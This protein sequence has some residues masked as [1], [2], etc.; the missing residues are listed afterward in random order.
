MELNCKTSYPE[1]FETFWKSYPP[2]GKPAS[3]NGK[4]PAMDVWRRM[5][6]EQRAEAMAAVPQQIEWGVLNQDPQFIPM[7]MTWL[8]QRRWLDEKPEGPKGKG[9]SGQDFENE[10]KLKEAWE[11]GW[12]E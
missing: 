9:L 8:R 3:R 2:R 4:G 6:Q 1:D 5:S 11:G 7:A 12:D 10:E